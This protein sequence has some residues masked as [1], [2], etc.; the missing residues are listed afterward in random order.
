MMSGE[1]VGDVV[2]GFLKAVVVVFILAVA[3][4]AALGV[5]IGTHFG[6]DDKQRILSP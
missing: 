6:Q 5:W 3:G 1:E 4:A 2:S